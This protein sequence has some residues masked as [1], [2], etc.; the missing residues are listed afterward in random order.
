[1]Q[2]IA[3]TISGTEFV[4]KFSKTNYSNVAIND[5]FYHIELLKKFGEN[6][7]SF[8]VNQKLAQIE[9]DFSGGD[10]LNISMD[11]MLYEVKVATSTKKLLEKYLKESGRENSGG[12]INIV[13]NMP[14][15]VLKVFPNEGG[16]TLEGDRLMIIEAMKMENI[17]KAPRTGR[18][19]KIYAREGTPVNKGEL[20][21]EI[22]TTK[23]A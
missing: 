10:T 11:G 19:K 14:G 15:M 3:L 5:K 13:A 12:I 20:L 22:D 18:V 4:A 6:I 7:F 9:M 16:L 1:M 17:M 2:E 23:E 21:M 8:S